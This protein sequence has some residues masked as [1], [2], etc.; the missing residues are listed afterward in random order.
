VLVSAGGYVN[1]K[2]VRSSWRVGENKLMCA[3]GKQCAAAAAAAAA[4]ISRSQAGN[5]PLD[6]REIWTELPL[7]VECSHAAMGEVGGGVKTLLH[8]EAQQ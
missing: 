5:I 7:R 8:L 2:Q 4:T 1:C 3:V 6:H